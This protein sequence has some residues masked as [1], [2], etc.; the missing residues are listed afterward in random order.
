MTSTR[1]K[2]RNCCNPY[3]S[4]LP[5]I[6][7]GRRPR[8]EI[9]VLLWWSIG[10]SNSWPLQCECSALPTALMPHIPALEPSGPQVSLL[11][12]TNTGLKRKRF[13]RKNALFRKRK[14]VKHLSCHRV[15]KQANQC[16]G[17]PLLQTKAVYDGPLCPD[18][19]ATHSVWNP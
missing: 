11:I 4:T 12:I 9:D 3:K 19:G 8:I 18:Q 14:S 1:H 7:K 6:Q 2:H 10:D 17:R 15:E 16:I 13:L 5:T